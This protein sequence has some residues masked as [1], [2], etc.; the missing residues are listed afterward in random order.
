MRGL[1]TV[2][3]DRSVLRM[4]SG[5][6]GRRGLTTRSSSAANTAMTFRDANANDLIVFLDCSS[7]PRSF[8]EFQAL[9]GYTSMAKPALSN[10]PAV[11]PTIAP[12]GSVTASPRV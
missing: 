8:E 9:A 10:C 6:Y 4:C 7:P 5:N 11:V 1:P 3:G 2:P 12:E